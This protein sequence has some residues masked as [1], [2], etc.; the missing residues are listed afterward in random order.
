VVV[1][2]V[3]IL[4]DEKTKKIGGA[5]VALLDR[6]MVAIHD[7]K[8]IRQD[9]SLDRVEAWKSRNGGH[10]GTPAS[11]ASD[12]VEGAAGGAAAG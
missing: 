8:S 3:D 9:P 5:V 12:S 1:C 11:V 2:L 4:S 7:L 6:A 10:A